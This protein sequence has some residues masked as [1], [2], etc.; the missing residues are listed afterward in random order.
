MRPELDLAANGTAGTAP[1]HV[2]LPVRTSVTP[3]RSAVPTVTVRLT[4]SMP[5]T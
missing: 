2:G 5:S 4:G 1:V 3:A